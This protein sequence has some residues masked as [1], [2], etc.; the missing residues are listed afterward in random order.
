LTKGPYISHMRYYTRK[1][2]KRQ[3]VLFIF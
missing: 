2:I 1:I 3:V